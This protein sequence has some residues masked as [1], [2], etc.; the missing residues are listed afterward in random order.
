MNESGSES[1]SGV[2]A[3]SSEPVRV[4]RLP[5]FGWGLG[6]GALAVVVIV[7][8]VGLAA[9]LSYTRMTSQSFAPQTVTVEPVSMGEQWFEVENDGT[10]TLQGWSAGSFGS[11]SDGSRPYSFD[12]FE[13]GVE[14]AVAFRYLVTMGADDD[15]QFFVG[16]EPYEP[17]TKGSGSVADYVFGGFGNMGNPI[18]DGQV[19]LII[20]FRTDP[21]GL[22]AT[23][24]TADPA[25]PA[26]PYFY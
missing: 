13:V 9:T 19:R 15:T 23:K 2:A 8:V 25:A 10:G 12:V 4:N 14:G 17:D 22:T 1:Q 11:A 3:E 5:G 21:E 26:A 7:G 6:V 16:D 24:V 20:E 18:T